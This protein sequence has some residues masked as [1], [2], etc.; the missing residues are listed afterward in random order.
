ME[1]TS[2]NSDKVFYVTSIDIGWLQFDQDKIP[3]V[4]LFFFSTFSLCIFGLRIYDLFY[5]HC[6]QRCTT[7][8]ILST[9]IKNEMEP[10]AKTITNH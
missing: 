6:S 7:T 1:H 8:I 9:A 2:K 3:R 10:V 4:S 5:Y